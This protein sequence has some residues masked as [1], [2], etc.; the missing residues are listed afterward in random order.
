MNQRSEELYALIVEIRRSFNA[1]K[2]FSDQ[3]NDDLGVT[4]AMRAVMEYL[5]EHGATSVAEIA[6]G[7]DV[8]RQHIQQLADS[9]AKTDLLGWEPNPRHKRSPLAVLTQEGTLKFA[10]IK[11]REA[12]VLDEIAAAMPDMNF[13]QARQSLGALR[14]TIGQVRG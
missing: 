9:L 3:S 6:R 10:E 1:L 7:K 4:A 2:T 5:S 12:Y 14:E 8:S 11:R 13:E